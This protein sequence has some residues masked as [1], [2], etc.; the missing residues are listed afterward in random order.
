MLLL[1]FL[2]QPRVKFFPSLNS[3]GLE[4][5]VQ[6]IGFELVI[7]FPR[8]VEVLSTSR[9]DK[10]RSGGVDGEFG[11]GGC[12]SRGGC[13]RQL[14]VQALQRLLVGFDSPVTLTF[15]SEVG[16]QSAGGGPTTKGNLTIVGDIFA[17]RMV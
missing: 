7:V 5:L 10:G 11:R 9:G 8:E 17:A 6:E 4:F 12:S 14:N 15:S 3:L 13:G 16:F 2:T 1:L